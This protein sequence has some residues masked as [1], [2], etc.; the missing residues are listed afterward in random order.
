MGSSQSR[1]RERLPPFLRVGAMSPPWFSMPLFLLSTSC[2]F[3][4]F[5]HHTFNPHTTISQVLTLLYM[6]TSWVCDMTCKYIHIHNL[7]SFF[8]FSHLTSEQVSWRQD[9]HVGNNILKGE[10]ESHKGKIQN[11]VHKILRLS[12]L[13]F[14][15][16]SLLSVSSLTNT[17]YS[18]YHFFVQLILLVFLYNN[19]MLTFFTVIILF[20]YV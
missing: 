10:I 4:R 18:C 7:Q 16:L 8:L 2:L 12:K 3:Q 15:I 9:S 6:V 17:C 11:G 5:I 14:W 20:Q 1:S 13:S 19:L